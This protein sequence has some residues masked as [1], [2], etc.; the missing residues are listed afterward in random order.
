MKTTSSN[1]PATRGSSRP[2]NLSKDALMKPAP[3]QTD[4][5]ALFDTDYFRDK[6]K[7]VLPKHL[8]PDRMA[9]VAFASIA[10]TPKLLD[11]S[12]MSLIEA[13]LQLGELG[14]EPAAGLGLAYLLP[15]GKQCK[16][17]IGY[18]GYIELMRRSGS[19]SQIEARVVHDHDKFTL[20][21]GLDMKLVHQ[22]CLEGD[23]GRIKLV[24]CIARLKDGGVHVEVMTRA[25]VDG[26]RERSMSKSSGP[27]VT[28]YEQMARKTVIRRAAN[29]LPLSPEIGRAI[30]IDDRNE[31]RELNAPPSRSRN[32]VV[33]DMPF[34]AANTTASEP[35]P[36][37]QP[38]QHDAETGEVYEPD[39]DE[40]VAAQVQESLR[41]ADDRQRAERAKPEPRT[42]EYTAWVLEKIDAALQ[43]GDMDALKRTSK[44]QGNNVMQA[45]GQR[46]AN[47][48]LDARKALLAVQAP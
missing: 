11:C 13:V 23:P 15:Y 42:P 16:V 30:D 31:E 22:P 25:E 21:L 12:Q 8:T 39:E 5:R 37:P 4:L 47:A 48:Y 27:W 17:I 18:K 7:E 38:E 26:I 1:T 32:A 35:E 43:A 14:L 33:V 9:K 34:S 29:Y 3:S 24:Y 36:E 6:L 2:V 46:V 45:D 40:G 10:R 19:L 20:R 41:E 28:D 44:L